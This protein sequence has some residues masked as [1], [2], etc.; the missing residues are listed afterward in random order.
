ME[1]LATSPGE[2]SHTITWDTDADAAAGYDVWLRIRALSKPPLYGAIQWPASTRTLR[3]GH[4]DG[5]PKIT[6]F[7]PV[8][9]TPVLDSLP[10]LGRIKDVTN[11][12]SYEVHVSQLPDTAIWEEHVSTGEPVTGL[13]YV[14]S[15]DLSNEQPGEYIVRI[16]ALDQSGNRTVRDTY[17]EVTE[18]SVYSPLIT[19]SYPAVNEH[20]VPGNAPVVVQF[21]RDINPY[22]IDNTT[23]T[24]SS[25]TGDKYSNLLYDY[26]SRTLTVVPDRPYRADEFHYSITSRQVASQTGHK[27]GGEFASCFNT[28]LLPPITEIDSLLPFRG[29]VET[30]VTTDSILIYYSGQSEHKYVTVF[31]L[32]GDTVANGIVE[33]NWQ[34]GSIALTGLLPKTYY[35]V[36]VSDSADFSGASDYMSYFITEDT[37]MPLMVDRSPAENA[38]LVGLRDELTVSFNKLLNTFTVDSSSLYLSGPT[39]K[40]DGLYDFGGDTASTITFNPLEDLQPSTEYT[41]VVTSHIQDNIGNAI[42]DQ[43]WAFTTGTFGRIGYDGGTVSSSEITVMFQLGAVRSGIDV[44]IGQ[45]PEYLVDCGTRSDCLG[46]AFDLKPAT[47]LVRPAVL[48]IAVPDSLM[49]GQSLIVSLYDTI[50][51]GWLDLGGSSLSES[52]VSVPINRL[53]RYGVFSQAASA[54][55]VDFESSLSLIPRVISPRTGSFNASLNVAYRLAQ[56]QPVEARIYDTRGEL[57]ATLANGTTGT[58]G[59]NL[60]EWDG[61][62]ADGDYAND[63]LYVLVIEAGGQ[64]VKKTF[65]IL[66]K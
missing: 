30:P 55:E 64:T 12:A 46:L 66:N 38:W 58:V 34:P 21:D 28:S 11:F 13:G 6:L 31:S 42:A 7:Y 3:I 22:S 59:D 4:I 47:D 57:V 27:M 52:R 19:G 65:V 51:G 32:Q 45:V 1:G 39:G 56:P 25:L 63:G 17:I 16:I 44:G 18:K 41:A 62:R 23:L 26:N 40:V 35:I 29:Q 60:I 15:V 53:G 54:A 43:S 20:N 49:S 61:K 9:N 33:G 2:V 50:T 10:I 36:R 48:T 5:R 24:L 37:Q 8:Q 14:T